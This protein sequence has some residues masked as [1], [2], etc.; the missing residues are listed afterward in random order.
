RPVSVVNGTPVSVGVGIEEGDGMRQAP[1]LTG[2]AQRLVSV[3]EHHAGLQSLRSMRGIEARR[4]KASALPL[5]F[6]Q[7]LASRR[8]RVSQA[9]VRST[10][11]RFG[12]TT[13]PFA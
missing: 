6:S 1:E 11:Q 13:N 3:R 10:I 2:T 8:Q 7:S 12:R 5:R 4:R 9:M